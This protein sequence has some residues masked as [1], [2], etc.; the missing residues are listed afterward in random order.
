MQTFSTVHPDVHIFI[1]VMRTHKTAKS[2][3][4]VWKLCSLAGVLVVGDFPCMQTDCAVQHHTD[5]CRGDCLRWCVRSKLAAGNHWQALL[6]NR[7]KWFCIFLDA[8]LWWR[9][10]FCHQRKT[11]GVGLS[12]WWFFNQLSFKFFTLGLEVFQIKLK[13]EIVPVKIPSLKILSQVDFFLY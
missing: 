12:D 9:W 3:S 2:S 7:M 10:D 1:P 13:V 5:C 8:L 4:V 11:N 6:L